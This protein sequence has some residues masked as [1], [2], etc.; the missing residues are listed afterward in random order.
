[1]HEELVGII[2][3]GRADEVERVIRDLERNDMIKLIYVRRAELGS[4]LLIIE[5]HKKGGKLC[6]ERFIS[7]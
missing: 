2:L 1:L 3:R 4:F 6:H 5:T 7:R